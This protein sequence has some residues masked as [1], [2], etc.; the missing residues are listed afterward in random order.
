MTL[1]ARASSLHRVSLYKMLSRHGN[2]G[3]D[4]L[5]SLL[6]ALGAQLRITERPRHRHSHA[7]R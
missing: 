4:S 5:I 6:D 1:V 3:I 7:A 2:P